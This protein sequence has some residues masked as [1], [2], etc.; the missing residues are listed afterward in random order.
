M[1]TPFTMLVCGPSGS[2]K[3]VF[4]SKLLTSGLINPF[5]ARIIWC[6]GV[7]QPQ[8]EDTSTGI[9]YHEGLPSEE[10]LQEGNMIL[11]IDDLMQQAKSS[12]VVSDI[13]TKYSHHNNI[14]C[15]CL[16]QNLFPKGSQIRNISLNAKYIVLMKN[17]RDRAQISHLARQVYPG[18]SECLTAAYD[19]ATKNPFG[20]LLLDFRN[21]TPEQLRVRTGLFPDD[22]MYAYQFPKV[23]KKK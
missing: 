10:L 23:Y 7:W 2:G 14:T 6:Y 9:E 8:F 1:Q 20:Y 12:G 5:P 18:R 22:V 13:F 15:I 11:V 3:S 21:T 4:T 17:S 16:M 19:D